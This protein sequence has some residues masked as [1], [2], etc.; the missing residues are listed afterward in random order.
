[1]SHPSLAVVLGV[2]SVV[3][4]HLC[5]RLSAAGFTGECVSRQPEPIG[6]P[7]S[8]FIWRRLDVRAPGD[9]AAPA[10]SVVFSLLPLWM[11]PDCLPRLAT[12]RQI[13]AVGTTSVFAKA[14]SADPREAELAGRI[15]AAERRLGEVLRDSDCAWTV[16][17]PTLI[18]DPGLD[19]NVSAIARFI[20]RFGFFPVVPPA[21]GLRQPIHADDVAQA[22]LAAVDNREARNRAFDL[23]GGETLPYREMVRRIFDGLGRRPVILPLPVGLLRLGLAAARPVYGRRYSPALFDRMNRDLAFDGTAARLALGIEPRPFRPVFPGRRPR[24]GSPPMV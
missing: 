2:T 3:G 13:V 18:Y 15:A 19:R 22:A 14:A 12:A 9:W 20:A 17:R 23:P 7:P 11:L 10:G 16:L 6:G 8:G 24:R 21:T 4:R 1:M 5:R